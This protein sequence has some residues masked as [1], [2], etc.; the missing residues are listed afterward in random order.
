MSEHP[1][2]THLR[3]QFEETT[4]KAKG[5]LDRA[6]EEKNRDLTDD[7]KTELEVLSKRKTSLEEQMEAAAVDWNINAQTTDKLLALKTANDHRDV[8]YRSIGQLVHDMLHQADPDARG[9]YQTVMKRAAQHMG[10]LAAET[11]PVAGDLAGMHVIPSVGPVIDPIPASMPFATGLGLQPLTDDTFTRPTVVDPDIDTGV[12]EQTLEKAELASKKFDVTS[13]PVT[14]KTVGGY[15]NVSQ[16]LITFRPG[17]LETIIRQMRKRLSRAIEKAMVAVPAA[18]TT[19]QPLESDADAAATLQAIYNAAATVYQKTGELAEWIVMGPLG[20]AMIGGK[21]DLAGRP[22]FPYLGA[23]NAP[24]TSTAS[25]F[26]SPVAGLQPIQTWAIADKSIYVG[27]GEGVEG[28]LYQYP[29]LEAVEP[30][31]L[32]RQI[33]VAG[34]LANYT[35]VDNAVVKLTDQTP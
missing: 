22:L 15:L 2:L 6:V 20:F 18:T 19:V 32:G 17:S 3:D 16:K 8:S 28:W 30:S 26:T 5:I 24:G 12:A 23:A 31:V 10:T 14:S 33:A 9:R 11:T 7:E 34:E 29:I 25:T 21:V 4:T 1:L 13:E 27:N 35:P